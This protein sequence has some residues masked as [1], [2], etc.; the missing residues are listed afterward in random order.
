[1]LFRSVHRVDARQTALCL[2]SGV[3]AVWAFAG[4]LGLITG[5][6]GLG[7]N[8]DQRI[9]F[10]SPVFGGVMLALVV[11]LPM[12]VAGVLA[13]QDNRWTPVAAMTAGLALIG[14]IAVQIAVIRE[15]SWLQPVCVLFGLTVFALG[16]A[17]WRHRRTSG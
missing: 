10:H 6:I 3:V 9:P 15:L 13:T 2:V 1:V 16:A 5:I 14:W 4:S 7:A 11:G 12:T 17:L 8:L